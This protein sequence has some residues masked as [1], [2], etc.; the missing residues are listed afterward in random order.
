[1][2][3]H[4]AGAGKT[5]FELL[6]G[7]LFVKQLA[8]QAGDVFLDLGCGRG[9]F[10][11][12][13]AEHIDARGAIHAIDIWPEGVAAVE[14][15]ARLERLPQIRAHLTDAGE[16]LPLADVSVDVGLMAVVLH[17]L[18]VENHHLPALEEIARVLKPGGRLAILEFNKIDGPPGPPRQ[19]RLAPSEVEEMLQPYG[20]K[21]ITRTMLNRNVYLI[22]FQLASSHSE[23]SA[24]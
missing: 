12:A 3:H 16:A 22:Q 7:T 17:D 10:S 19:I 13:A 21:E 6:D 1:M 2:S 15:R 18:V 11:F 4:P 14:E 9:H 8:L 24:P 20:F 23:R 5:G